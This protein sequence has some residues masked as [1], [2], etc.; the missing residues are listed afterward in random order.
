MLHFRF[1]TSRRTS[2]LLLAKALLF[3]PDFSRTTRMASNFVTEERGKVYTESYRLYFKNGANQV[4]SPFH[5]IPLKAVTTETEDESSTCLFNMVVEVPKWSNAKMEISKSQPMNPIMQ[6]VKKGK[7][8]F[9]GNVFPH[10]GYI[11]NYGAFP[12]T[13]EDPNTTYSETGTKGDN[14]PLDVCDISNI[15]S[16]RGTVIQVKVLGVLLMIDE[17]ETDWKVMAINSE[18][19]LAQHMQDITDVEKYKPG[20]LHATIEWFKYYKG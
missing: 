12:Q 18:D 15:V 17:G 14:D 11:W 4:I 5:D 16:P 1:Y 20:L 10:R 6:D 8:R 9:V 13:W 2:E 3:I 7:V 19:P